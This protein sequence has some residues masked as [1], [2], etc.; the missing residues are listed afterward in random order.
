VLKRVTVV[1]DGASLTLADVVNVAR[2]SEGVALAQEA[3]ERI[4]RGRDIVEEAL[5]SEDTVYGL[6]TGVGSRKRVPLP[7]SEI[8]RFNR[9]IVL[10]SSV[11][12]GPASAEDVVRASLL[13]LANGFAT[14]TVGVRQELAELVVKALNDGVHLPVRMLG[15]VGQ[16]DLAPM[17]DLARGLLAGS[18]MALE[19]GEGLA[20]I[21]NNAFSTGLSA[22]AL[23]DCRRLFDTLDIA[24]ALDM[25]AF[26][27]NL[28]ILDDLVLATRP[29][30]GIR[31]SLERIKPLLDGSSLWSNPP[32][33]LQDPLSFRSIVH[34]HG[35]GRDALEFVDRQI[36]V[37]LNASQGS[38][39]VSLDERR[40]ISSANFESLPLAAA[41]DFLRIALAPMLTSAN[42]RSIKL[43]QAPHSGLPTGLAARDLLAE[44]A[45][46][47]FGVATQALTVEARLL[48][49]P[50]SF[51]LSSSSQEEGI[52]DRTS[53]A[54]LAA[55]RLAEMVE[56][57]ERIAA[58]ELV[59][60][61]QAVDLR[62][63]ARLGTGTQRVLDLVR[64]RIPFTRPGEPVPQDL[65]PIR[66]LVKSGQLGSSSDANLMAAD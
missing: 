27:C 26:A 23:A 15:S 45:L 6:N 53:I 8:D 60:A 18:D 33:N 58:I 61:A 62:K 37:E 2:K 14:G 66:D 49:Q 55:R 29:Y 22:L 43:L 9:L 12:Q 44:D 46:S 39:V 56:L 63:E 30:V 24:S 21:S 25:E 7:P 3:V 51:E 31:R 34:V 1:L 41:L 28:G 54:S 48:A 64:E 38:P 42:E 20:L 16:A 19:P 52:E 59:V 57:G 4:R 13:R 47:E 50:V 32:R 10:N 40:V 11:G 5:A 65:E 35:A 36:G 17:A